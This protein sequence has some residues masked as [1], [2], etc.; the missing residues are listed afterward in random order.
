MSF[1]RAFKSFIALVVLTAF[2][3][4]CMNTTHL[5]DMVIVEGMAI[6]RSDASY[7]LTIQTLNINANTS[8]QNMSG[9]MTINSTE[10]GESI[11]DAIASLSR[12]FSK[13]MF[14]G[15]NKLIIIGDELAR[16]G[17]DEHIDYFLRSSDSRAD[18]TVVLADESAKD[19]IDSK[20]N[21]STVPCEN[22]L[23]VIKNNEDNGLSTLVTTSDIFNLYNDKTSDFV[24][25]VLKR[26]SKK[27][28]ASVGTIA[29]FSKDRLVY[30]MSEDE[31]IGYV[32]LT[33][34]V[35]ELS[36][37]LDDDEL[38][39][40][41]VTLSR[42]RCKKRINKINDKLIFNVECKADMLISSIEKGSNTSLKNEDS[43]RILKLANDRLSTLALKAI[44]TCQNNNCDAVRIGEYVAKYYPDEYSKMADSWS[45]YFKQIESAVNSSIKLKKLSNN[46]QIE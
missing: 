39:K 40:I 25:P 15:Q 27:S 13:R 23:N 18:V 9:N 4:G 7:E 34:K 14:F 6:D 8:T 22:I 36:L 20:E 1:L 16:E 10:K 5:K 24:L 26:D 37:A 17:F 43:D 3:S 30:K 19:I 42:I 11:E 29:L 28:A 35:R 2:L 33:N 31:A 21:D 41:D 38:G 46:T 32:I 45:V 12:R 44:Y